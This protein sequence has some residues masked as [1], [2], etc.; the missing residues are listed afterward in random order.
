MEVKL[1]Y[2]RRGLKVNFPDDAEIIRP[3]F[4]A[5]LP[6]EERGLREALYNPIAGRPLHGIVRAGDRVVVVHTDIT[7][8]TPNRTILPVLLDDLERAGVR[9][10][11]ITLLNGLGTHRPQ[12]EVA[13]AAGRRDRRTL[14]LP[15]ARL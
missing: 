3:H 1:A 5:A 15:A 12:S 14:P 9:R 13:P 11:D 7:R 4:P 10:E 6:D 8:A 2:G